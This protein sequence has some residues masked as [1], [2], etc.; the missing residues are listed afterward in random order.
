MTL[1]NAILAG[2]AIVGSLAS[3]PLAKCVGYVYLLCISTLLS[4]M[5][6]IFTVVCVKESLPGATKV[7]S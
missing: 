5:A 7:L 6:L 2:G 1:L 4:F 3:S